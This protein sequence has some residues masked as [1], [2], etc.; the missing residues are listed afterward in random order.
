MSVLWKA[1][2]S[3][4]RPLEQHDG[5]GSRVLARERA[6]RRVD[7]ASDVGK[8]HAVVEFACVQNLVTDRTARVDRVEDLLVTLG[9]GL[10]PGVEVASDRDEIGVGAERLAEGSAVGRFQASSRRS[11]IA[12]ATAA[13]SGGACGP[14]FPWLTLCI[15]LA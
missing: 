15:S 12:S 2:I 6:A 5:G 8:D 10:P 9:D 4:R 7:G 13:A 3:Y 1:A 14:G 11:T